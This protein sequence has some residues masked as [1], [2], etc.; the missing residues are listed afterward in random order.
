MTDL[1]NSNITDILPEVLAKKPEVR[2]LGYA[3]NKALQRLIGYCQNISIY[4][5]IDTAPEQLLDLLAVEFNTQYYDASL[6]IEIKRKL[7]KNTLVWYMNTGTVAC[8]EEAVVTIFGEGSRVAEW[9]EYGGDPYY[10]RI[11]TENLGSND[12]MLRQIG[13]LVSRVQ[14]VRSQLEEVIVSATE[15]MQMF[16]GCRVDSIMDSIT[17]G[18]DMNLD[19]YNFKRSQKLNLYHGAAIAATAKATTI[20]ID[21]N[22]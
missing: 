8:V 4:A 1:Y 10:F 17:L 19:E 22:I 12:E 5:A 9:F 16:H 15:H 7:V 14:N 21:M 11:Y 18:I 20:G 3:I 13:D 2:A 6:D